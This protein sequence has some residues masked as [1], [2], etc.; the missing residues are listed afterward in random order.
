MKYL[1]TGAVS[2]PWVGFKGDHLRVNYGLEFICRHGTK[3]PRDH[4]VRLTVALQDRE[5]LVAARRLQD[6]NNRDGPW[7]H[8][9]YLFCLLFCKRTIKCGLDK[10][11]TVPMGNCCEVEAS[12]WGLQRQP[13]DAG[14][15]RRYTRTGRH[16]EEEWRKNTGEEKRNN[17][18]YTNQ[19]FK[20][21]CLW[22][23]LL[24]NIKQG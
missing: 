20:T 2:E 22:T 23:W 18:Y 5:V 3:L 15:S 4:D 16:P 1:R 8:R 14:R 7:P 13:A 6:R 12:N 21:S 10:T 24:P 19:H 9:K 11:V 17:I